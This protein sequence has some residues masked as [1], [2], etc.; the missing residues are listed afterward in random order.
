MSIPVYPDLQNLGLRPLPTLPPYFLRRK[1]LLLCHK[2]AFLLEWN[3]IFNATHTF[4]V[5]GPPTWPEH[6]RPLFK[7]IN[8]IS[9]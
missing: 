8:I 1:I 3:G 7:Y 6:W 9:Q 4:V 5:A 2:G